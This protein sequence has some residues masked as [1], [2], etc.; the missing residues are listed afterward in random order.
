MNRSFADLLREMTDHLIKFH[1]V[2]IVKERADVSQFLT[3]PIDTRRRSEDPIIGYF[4]IPPEKVSIVRNKN[5]KPLRY[6]QRLD[7][8]VGRGYAARNDP[9]WDA[10]DV[11]HIHVNRK[12]GR[13]FGTP[14]IISA[15][16]D[17]IALRQIEQDMQN[18][19]HRELFPI[20]KYRLEDPD[21]D[22]PD[23][24]EIEAIIDELENMRTEGSVFLPPGH[25]V[26]VVGAEG[27]VL[28][29]GPYL[30]HFKERVA[31]GL[32]V[33]P[34]HLGMVDFAGANRDM[35]DRLD[36]I[37][38]DKVKFY[39]RRFEE[40]VTFH[41]FNEL[42][43]DGG[44][45][46]YSNLD[47]ANSDQ[48]KFKFKEIDLDTMIKVQAHELSKFT[49]NISEA[50]E[51]RMALG[52]PPDYDPEDTLQAQT[53]KVQMKYTPPP[54]PTAS[55]SSSSKTSKPKSSDGKK[56]ASAGQRNLPNSSARQLA[57]KIRPQNQHGR[58]L[59]PGVRHYDEPDN[60]EEVDSNMAELVDLYLNEYEDTDE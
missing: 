34:H 21:V 29:I 32:G 40:I 46:P 22:D 18:L 27:E 54:A 24:P 13:L 39:Q 1:N 28:E 7:D 33:F 55:S 38:Y 10:E 5:N 59:S 9:Q 51:T 26:E 4:M 6:K 53:A 35:T 41:I 36:Q 11:I 15:L 16:D 19:V 20:F 45:D 8:N 52:M 3:K 58:S 14:F 56:P 42:L 43:L 48:C 2:F 60:I 31:T 12:T 44:F 49:A 23:L 25:N 30:N 17:I 50:A 47:G 37:L 57:N